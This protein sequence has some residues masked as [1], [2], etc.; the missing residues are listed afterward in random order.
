AHIDVSEL[1][2]GAR[3]K[4]DE[5]EKGQAQ[6]FAWWK[7][8]D[9]NDGDVFWET[10]L[11]KG[12]PGWHIE[13]S[14]MSAKHLTDAFD[15]NN[16]LK[17]TKFETIDIH[18]GGVD[19]MFPHHENEIAQTEGAVGKQFVKY[20]MHCEHLLVDNKKMSKSLG[21]FYTLRDVLKKGYKPAGIRYILLSTHY[22]QQ[23][24]FTFEALEAAQQAVERINNFVFSLKTYKDG[25]E[26]KEVENLIKKIK[27]DFEKA[28]DDD[29][30]I[31]PAL[32]VIFDFVNEINSLLA[33]KKISKKQADNCL[34][35]V[36]AFNSVL[37]VIEEKS[38]EIPKEAK[39]L[40]QEREA[41]RKS[42]DWKKS[43]EI[44]D[45]LDKMGIVV[46]DSP[47]GPKWFRK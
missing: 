43:D 29:L 17:P 30:N 4:H 33:D 1:K 42:K 3:V 38:E 2:A 26:S 32:A 28:M 44:R 9:E 11:G 23:L 41:A 5:Y 20:W 8:W 46:M 24:N 13:C 45:K 10:E 47:E 14:A 22:K 6:D 16:I 7:A 12:R 19:N 27:S 35:L 31:S 39:K 37:G 21:N 25:K 18:T 36:R 34:N 15:K 40:I